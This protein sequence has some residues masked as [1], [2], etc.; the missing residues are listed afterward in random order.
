MPC[1]ARSRIGIDRKT[2]RDGIAGDAVR[3]EHHVAIDRR[4]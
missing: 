4:T 1:D 3:I 2:F